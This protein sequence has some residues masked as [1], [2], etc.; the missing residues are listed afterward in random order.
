MDQSG[1]HITEDKIAALTQMPAP[2]NVNEV[3]IFLGMINYYSRFIRNYSDVIYPLY[4]LLRKDSEFV[5]T[6]E[7]AEAFREIKRR[8]ISHEV[9]MYYDPK[10]PVKLTCDASPTGV[11]AVLAHVLADESDRPIAF[12]SRALN[13]AEKNYSQIDREALAIVNAVKFFHSMYMGRSLF[14]RRTIN[15][16][17][18]YLGIKRASRKWRRVDCRGG[19]CFY[20]ATIMR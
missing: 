8:L 12:T 19:A 17:C 5:W 9:L 15:R 7:C 13:K 2:R 3:Q 18:I 10:L 11:G 14:W 6:R 16:W 4:Q 20:Q 1:I